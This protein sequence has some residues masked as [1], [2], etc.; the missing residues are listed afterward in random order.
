[1]IAKLR[2]ENKTLKTSIETYQ[3]TKTDTIQR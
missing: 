2:R 1:M 3:K